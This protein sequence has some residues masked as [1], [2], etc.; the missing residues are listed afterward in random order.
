[1]SA[2]PSIQHWPWINSK[3]L[4]VLFGDIWNN[5]MCRNAQQILLFQPKCSLKMKMYIFWFSKCVPACI[6]LKWSSQVSKIHVYD[7]VCKMLTWLSITTSS[8]TNPIWPDC[9]SLP[10]SINE[11]RRWPQPFSRWQHIFNLKAV[12]PMRLQV[13]VSAISS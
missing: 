11:S 5:G 6:H 12:L 3:I 4:L 8:V 2:L 13:C 10:C 1:M 9:K 7:L